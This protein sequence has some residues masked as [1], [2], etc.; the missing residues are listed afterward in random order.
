M[1][2]A[3][4]ILHAQPGRMELM[5]QIAELNTLVVDDYENIRQRLCAALRDLGITR[6][7]EA[8]NGLE[9]LEKLRAAETDPPFDIVF[10]DIVMPE[11][12]GFELT[13]EIRNTSAFRDILIV[14][15]ST[16][17]D[18]NYLIR[19]LRLGADDYVPKPID[20]DLLKKVIA[21]VITPIRE[22]G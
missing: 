9:A 12:D 19:G 15:V 18:T 8:G 4:Q 2:I 1:L 5:K 6:I 13:E 21:R 17:Y 14:L 7:T 16:H 11:M 3:W 10:T 20:H 22:A